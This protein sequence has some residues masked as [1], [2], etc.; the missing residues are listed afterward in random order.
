MPENHEKFH[1]TK[2]NRQVL[3]VDDEQ[4]NREL[5]GFILKDSCNVLCASNGADAL[6]SIRENHETLSLVLLDLLMPEMNGLELLKILKSD[7]E[8]AQ[9]PVIV[10]TSERSAEVESLHMG[11]IDFISKPYTQPEVILARVLRI[12]EMAEDRQIIRS[13]EK[14][15]LTGLY[16]RE[17]FYRYA[18]QLDRNHEALPMDA[19]VIDINHFRMINERYGKAY[20]DAV[21]RRI[22]EKVQETVQDADGIV[23]RRDAD[24]FL[25]YCPHGKDYKSILDSASDGLSADTYI[26]GNRVR[27]RMGI[28]PRVDKSI[29]IERRFDR[30]KLAADSIRNNYVQAIAF[31]D[32]SLHQ[33]EIYTEQLLDD[34]QE[35]IAQRQFRV[36]YQPKFDIRSEIPVLYGAEALIRWQ[37][38]T[39]GMINPGVFIPLFEENG[40][41][42][43]LD[44]YVWREA[45]AQIRDWKDRLGL[46][47]PVSVNVSRID[48]YDPNLIDTFHHLMA[49]YDLTPDLYRLEI[50]ESAYTQDSAQIIDTVNRLRALGFRVE[51]DDF[52]TGYS[53]L[54]MIS[55][56]PIDAL[57]LDMKFIRNA[58]NER[59]D[60]R[61]LELIL[62]IADYL[63]VPVIAEGV[64]TEEQLN[65]LR[66]MGCDIVQGFYFSKPIPSEE[67]ERFMLE[68][69]RKKRP[70]FPPAVSVDS[71]VSVSDA[72]DISYANIAHALSS[73]FESIYYVDSDTG[74]YVEFSS[75]GRY[76]DLQIARNG[77]DFFGDTQR[78]L[79]RF[80]YQ[81]DQPRVSMAMQKEFL[82]T[83][84]TSESHFSLTYRLMIKNAPV[85]YN[86]KVVKA[87]GD[88]HHIVI[89]VSN[90]NDLMKQ[91]LDYEETKIKS[92]EFYNIAQA[93]SLD[94][95]SIYYVDTLTGMYTEFTAQGSYENLHIQ[96]SGSDFFAECQ[97]NLLNVVYPEDQKKVSAALEKSELLASLKDTP[98]FTLD[99]RLII[100]GAPA[101]YRMKV[102][103]VETPDNHHIVIGISNIS[104]QVVREHA[105]EL[106]QKNSV[107]YSRIA[108]ALAQD[109]FTV[110]YV[111]TESGRFMEYSTQGSN[112]SLTL[113][114]TG[115][116]FFEDTRRNIMRVVLDADREKAFNVWQKENILREL[117]K[118]HSFST[119]Y[120]LIL[121]GTP[122][123]VNI[124]VIPM[125][126]GD[127]HHVVV[128]ISNIDAQMKREREFAEAQ[129]M[130]LTDALTGV[131]N[132][133]AYAQAE[134]KF[135]ANIKDGNAPPFAIVVF[136]L[137]ELKTV[138]DTL[139]HNAG[140]RYIKDACALICKIFQHSPVY[141]VGGDEFAAILTGHDYDNRAS[142]ITALASRNRENTAEENVIIAA[143]CS[144]YIP[145]Q[146]ASMAA[147]F[148][149]ADNAMY[150]NK[151]VLKQK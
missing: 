98:V 59:K 114:R 74:H 147:V 89:G 88:K 31:Y 24:T 63:S 61:M 12:I 52:G 113:E 85:Y 78:N 116:D 102:V 148:E 45:A 119:S 27:L 30:A 13:T 39:L 22:G 75:Q 134:Q 105:Y 94:F 48:M 58:F 1:S 23:C 143:G 106:A 80:V 44:L 18:E 120:R 3:V 138:N 100:D 92:T 60:I 65:A 107:T 103:P 47:I 46:S 40:L 54:N 67:Y 84:L 10:I 96:T 15:A 142:L 35:A 127:D 110:Y 117:E 141:R 125:T 99:Y 51:M 19:I 137:N 17:Y 109:Y 77:T 86:L 6:A 115:E 139:G 90:V 38:P 95:E 14:D 122:V 49:E 57:K 7:P 136:D 111:N 149:R 55:S 56:L 104:M 97:R 21:L 144:E 93:L 64:E 34:F 124:K 130:A 123:Y 9:I 118:S 91:A 2:Q 50:T 20:A 146:D 37:H 79:L 76:E 4:I 135:N 32:E 132:K 150:E 121:D 5:L 81:E 28:Y 11:A 68:E 16:N 129:Q 25:I 87:A 101:Y 126:D 69:K 128:G 71:P 42:Q 26:S 145:E 131:K 62:D 73:G 36:F 108:Q 33:K 151:T 43:Q 112:H 29:D 70:C 8:L 82:M 72:Q 140:D 83:Q 53:S 41:I 133:R 66:A